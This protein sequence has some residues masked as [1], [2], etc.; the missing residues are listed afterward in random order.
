MKSLMLK[1]D[2][3]TL[4]RLQRSAE[5]DGITI[6]AAILD[7]IGAYIE[8]E[9]AAAQAGADDSF[10]KERPA[11]EKLLAAILPQAHGLN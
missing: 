4:A 3:A 11:P 9:E 8:A 5:R 2:N 10:G 7:G 1:I 6:N